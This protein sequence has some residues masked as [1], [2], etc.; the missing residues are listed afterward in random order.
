MVS[1]LEIHGLQNW[2]SYNESGMRRLGI[3]MWR[4]D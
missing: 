3:I 1:A 4:L 2:C